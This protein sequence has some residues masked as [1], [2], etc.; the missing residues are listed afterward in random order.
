MIIADNLCP[1]QLQL[2]H[3]FPKLLPRTETEH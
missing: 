2:N 1:S 3:N